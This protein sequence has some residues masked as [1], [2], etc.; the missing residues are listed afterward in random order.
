MMIH[1]GNTE[2][3]SQN[4]MVQQKAIVQINELISSK[5]LTFLNHVGLPQTL[6]VV[7]CWYDGL[8]QLRKGDILLIKKA[9]KTEY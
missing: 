1:L 8:L 4:R 5:K 9:C 6:V 2:T 3:D 7:K